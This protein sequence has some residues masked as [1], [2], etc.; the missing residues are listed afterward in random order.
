MPAAP[1]WRTEKMIGAGALS[2]TYGQNTLPKQ[3]AAFGIN[4]SVG[5][6]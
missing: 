5:G 3:V 6:G 2:Q 1:N 4:G